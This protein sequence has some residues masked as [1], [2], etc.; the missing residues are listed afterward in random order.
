VADLL[1]LVDSGLVYRN[2]KPHLR[3]I[4]AWHPSLAQRD[5]GVILAAFDLGEA[6]ESLDYGTWLAR[7][8]D[9]GKTWEPPRPLFRDNV[10][11]P[12]THAVR[13][14]RMRD[15][16]LVAFGARFHRDNP[17]EGLT[18]RANLG[19]VPVDLILLKSRDG[20]ESWEGPVT[21]K[22]PLVGPSF[23]ICHRVIELADGRWLA[24]TATWKGWN[25]AA[26]NGMKAIALVSRDKGQTWPE[27]ITIADQYER[28]IVSWEQGLTQLADGRLLAVIWCFDEKAGKSLPNGFT[29]SR[30]GRTFSPLREN[31]LRGETAKVLTLTDGR[32]L[33]LYRRLDKPGLWANLV[34]IDGDDWVNLAELPLWR[35]PLSGMLGER[36]SGDELSA[37]K[38]GFPSMLQLP[39]G[40]VLAMFWCLEECVHCIRWV[41]LRI[42]DQAHLSK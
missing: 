15:G 26:P 2:P 37:L 27:W 34:R 19:Y 41:R 23:E 35:G 3:S 40:D 21:I 11:Y 1:E 12:S 5:D 24:P 30:D 38:F 18:N 25:G 4:H 17:E 28:G 6:V 36:N 22:T 20:G 42:G 14:S 33:C 10:S 9:G 31:G 13:V 7:S 29:L 8:H 16:T 32:V 39:D